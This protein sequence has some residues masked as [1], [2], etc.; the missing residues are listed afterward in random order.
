[1][2]LS[3]VHPSVPYFHSLPFILLNSFFSFSPYIHVSGF[4]LVIF[5]ISVLCFEYMMYYFFIFI[6]FIK[7]NI[8]TIFKNNC[9]NTYIIYLKTNHLFA[10]SVSFFHVIYYL[11]FSYLFDTVVWGDCNHSFHNCC[12]SL[13]V[14]QN[15]RCPLCQQEWMVQR[16]GKWYNQS[17]PSNVYVGSMLPSMSAVMDGFKALESGIT[18]HIW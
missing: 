18:K 8:L 3:F 2:S 6:C 17:S 11:L 7:A 14:K 1:M 16:I 15:N 13:W 12:M 5:T 9:K 4:S 10:F